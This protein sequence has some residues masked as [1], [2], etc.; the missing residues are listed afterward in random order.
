M[1]CPKEF[2][3]DVLNIFYA[4]WVGKQKLLQKMDELISAFATQKFCRF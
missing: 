1:N 2:D 3:P 4:T